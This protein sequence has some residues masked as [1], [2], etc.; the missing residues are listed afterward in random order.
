M[1]IAN[2][3]GAKNDEYSQPRHCWD[4]SG[5]YIYGVSFTVHSAQIHG[6][7]VVATYKHHR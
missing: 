1:Q 7:H 3:Y 5:K 6:A 2:F 4:P